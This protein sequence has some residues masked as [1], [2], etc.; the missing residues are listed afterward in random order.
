MEMDKLK[1]ATEE[2]PLTILIPEGSSVEAFM[3]AYKINSNCAEFL[4]LSENWLKES[5]E[6]NEDLPAEDYLMFLEE[7]EEEEQSKEEEKPKVVVPALHRIQE[8][9]S[10]D[11]LDQTQI[12][13][14]I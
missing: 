14:P 1:A 4:F 8:D 6:K 10:E 7:V 12:N 11:Y 3:K 5:S 13:E 2:E 9:P